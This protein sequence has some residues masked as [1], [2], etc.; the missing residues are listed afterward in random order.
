MAGVLGLLVLSK[1]RGLI[2][3]YDLS[4]DSLLRVGFRA[5]P[6]LVERILKGG[7]QARP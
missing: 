7:E 5:D 3:A 6:D 2:S 4:T 1:Q